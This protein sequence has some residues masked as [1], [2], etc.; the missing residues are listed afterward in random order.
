M[1]LA[2]SSIVKTS[3]GL[4]DMGTVAFH[5]GSGKIKEREKGNDPEK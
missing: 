3:F 1:H 5:S 4:N 2:T